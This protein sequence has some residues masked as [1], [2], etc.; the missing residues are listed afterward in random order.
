[1]VTELKAQYPNMSDAVAEILSNYSLDNLKD[2]RET[3]KAD[4]EKFN[5]TVD[6]NQVMLSGGDGKPLNMEVQML[7]GTRKQTSQGDKRSS[8]AEFNEDGRLSTLVQKDERSGNMEGRFLNEDMSVRV[9]KIADRVRTHI[10]T[11]DGIGVDMSFRGRQ[12]TVTMDDG[13][14]TLK[15]S[16]RTGQNGS[17]RASKQ[18]CRQH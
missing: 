14:G 8:V 7:D 4:G 17:V 9:R 6:G 1:M 10:Q 2:I 3:L 18:L 12:G 16:T 15:A 5:F 13:F 11:G